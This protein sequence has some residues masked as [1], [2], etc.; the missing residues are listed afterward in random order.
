MNRAELRKLRFIHMAI[1]LGASLFAGISYYIQSYRGPFLSQSALDEHGLTLEYSI[2][3]WL[4][5]LIL[6]AMLV[7]RK[8]LSKARVKETLDAK[9]L[10]YRQVLIIQWA[11]IEFMGISTL[12]VYI[13]SGINNIFLYGLMTIAYQLYERPHALKTIKDLKLNEEEARE[14]RERFK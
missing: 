6:T 4:F 14:T 7:N 1:A 8:L 3:I 11:I 12:I 2:I 5:L 10:S 13:I 9:L